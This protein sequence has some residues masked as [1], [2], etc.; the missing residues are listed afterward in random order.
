M[1]KEPQ[2]LPG[3]PR[4]IK[5]EKHGLTPRPKN[6]KRPEAPPAPPPKEIPK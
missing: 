5:V 1:A 2:L 6:L 4:E 3:S